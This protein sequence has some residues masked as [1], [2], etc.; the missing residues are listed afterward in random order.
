MENSI[1]ELI[2]EE[3]DQRLKVMAKPDYAWP[4]KADITDAI[5]IIMSIS[6]SLFLIVLCMTGVI[7]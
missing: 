3:T 1:E 7:A 5:A 6:V 4:K 2:Y